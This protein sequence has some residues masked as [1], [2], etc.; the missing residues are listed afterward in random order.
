MEL[1]TNARKTALKERLPEIER[2][3]ETVEFLKSRSVRAFA[4][5]S[6]LC[7]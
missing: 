1:N 2:T 5:S 3:L 6:R 4:R 7:S